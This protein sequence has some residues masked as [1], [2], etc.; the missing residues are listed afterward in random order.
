MKTQTWTPLLV[1]ETVYSMLF[2]MLVFVY[3]ARLDLY[4]VVISAVYGLITVLGMLL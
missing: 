4:M 3:Q 1:G 2:G